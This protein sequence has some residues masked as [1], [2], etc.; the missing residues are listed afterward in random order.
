MPAPQGEPW[1]I[2][3][4]TET[5]LAAFDSADCFDELPECDAACA[6]GCECGYG[7]C[8]DNTSI[9]LA[10]DSWRTR[11]DDDYPGSQ[12]FR[13]GINMGIGWWDCPVRVQL[14]GSYAGYDLSG[15]DG[16]D[17]ADPLHSS[18]AEQ[19]MFFTGG[20]YRRSD[21]CG[22]VPCSWGAVIDVNYDN[23]F[24][25]QAQEILLTQARGIVGYAIDECNE[26]GIWGASRMNWQRIQSNTVDR[27]RV[28]GLT[29]ANLFWHRNWSFG[30]DTWLY[31]GAAEEPAEWILGLSGQAPLSHSVALFGGFA[32]GIPSAPEGDPLGDQNY[33][34]QYW[35]L[36]FGIVWYPGC[37][38]SSDKVSGHAGLPLLPVAD[39]G[40]FMVFARNGNL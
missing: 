19:Q 10:A 11:A 39:N 20:V 12:G 5:R 23:H 22:G 35:N 4:Q 25:E 34:E 38:A 29:Q 33:S 13:T 31:V 36:S 9:F 17:G 3:G 37:K 30:G 24:G 14:G 15:R 28:R 27:F 16:D 18:S 21:V 6:D 2:R 8:W 26:F 32:W 7:S 40:T 1:I